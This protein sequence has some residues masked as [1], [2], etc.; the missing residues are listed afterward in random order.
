MEHIKCKG[1]DQIREELKKVEAQGGEGLM[2]RKPKSK[3][4]NG[5]S[6]TLLKIKSFHDAEAV[7]IGYVPSTSGAFKCG[8]LLC[9]ME[10]GKTFKVGS[11]MTNADR[12]K[13]P[14]KGSIITYR[15][16]ELTNSGNPRF[17]TYVGVRVDMDKPKD[18]VMPKKSSD[19]AED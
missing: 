19:H 17:P 15:F 2:I 13:P 7:V 8:S 4:V 10:C 12:A 6:D 18:A 3:Y 5:R 1:A 11:G 14:K 9:R 16:Q